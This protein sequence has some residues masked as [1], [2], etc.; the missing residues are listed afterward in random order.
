MF[1]PQATNRQ[2]SLITPRQ[3]SVVSPRLAWMIYYKEVW[4]VKRVCEK[5]NISRKTFYKWWNR[6]FNS[7]Y[8][9]KSLMDNSR[10]PHK[11][12]MATPQDIVQKVVDAHSVTGYGQRRLKVYLSDNFDIH[13]SEHTIWKLLKKYKN[14]KPMNSRSPGD[15]IHIATISLFNKHGKSASIYTA[16]DDSTQMRI[17]RA[18]KNLS[19]NNTADFLKLIIEKYPFKIK[20]VLTPDTL[21]FK[22]LQ[23]E[24]EINT[25]LI[26]QP[27]ELL[28]KAEIE[29][30]F[31][32]ADDESDNLLKIT[33]L[34]T[35]EYMDLEFE[36][37]EDINRY[38]E[39]YLSKYNNH[40]KNEYLSG[41]TPLQK[42][43]TF[44]GFQKI[45]YF[46]TVIA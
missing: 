26:E 13:L 2:L 37:I 7:N 36:Y 32:S 40:E 33:D 17:S 1:Y 30:Q 16:I 43:R 20:K 27:S 3:N 15:K 34:I 28:K 14:A 44:D 21:I 31:Y 22:S 6:Y 4:N 38:F 24:N 18:Y 29:Q 25:I 8:D 19:I 35:H 11:S 39:K 45:N 10:K 9:S 12:P 23:L 5:F 42:L 46:E 41:L